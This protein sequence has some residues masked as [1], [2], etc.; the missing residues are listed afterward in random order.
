[1]AEA[2]VVHE[3]GAI[4]S[5]QEGEQQVA[6]AAPASS[7]DAITRGEVSQQIATAKKYP[8]AIKA[9]LQMAGSLA[10]MDEE[11]AGSCF[12]HLERQGKTIEGPSIRLAEIFA[13]SWGNL[14]FGSRIVDEQERYIVAQGFCHDL[15]TN[16]AA[17]VEVLRRIVDKKGRRFN[18]DMIQVTA[19]AAQSIALRNAILR[20][21]PRVFVDQI[22][23]QAKAVAVGNAS[24]LAQ[25]RQT[26]LDRLVKMG[27]SLERIFAKLGKA[28]VE[29]IGLAE[30]EKLIG[31]GTAIKEGSAK[32]DEIFPP[33]V[34]QGQPAA[35]EAL[36]SKSAEVAAHVAAVAAQVTQPAAAQKPATQPAAP[37]Q[38]EV[39][40]FELLDAIQAAGTPAALEALAKKVEA[41]PAESAERGALTEALAK[42]AQR[43]G[44]KRKA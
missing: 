34:V 4:E 3:D 17:A 2:M 25:R 26:V 16:N 33:V 44:G 21:V 9:A 24:T 12:Y 28:G 8:R 41:L 19:A 29:E 6:L 36:P 39:S 14:R 22:F 1:M 10:T 35:A 32:L 20:V 5:F 42:A 31:W 18:D 11:T 40:P 38:A 43:V 15:Q 30:L 37:A 13:S 27:A 7:L 23:K